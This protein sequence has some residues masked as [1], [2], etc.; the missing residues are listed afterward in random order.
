MFG[1][2]LQTMMFIVCGSLIRFYSNFNFTKGGS[3][4][5]EF[6][7]GVHQVREKCLTNLF[8]DSIRSIF[9]VKVAMEKLLRVFDF[10]LD[11]ELN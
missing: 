8:S 1:V 3:H 10:S 11:V 6:L 7:R 4:G 5:I 2:P 9:Q